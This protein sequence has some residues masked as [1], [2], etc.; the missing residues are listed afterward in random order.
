MLCPSQAK[1]FDHTFIVLLPASVKILRTLYPLPAIGK[2][3]AK[4]TRYMGQVSLGRDF[5]LGG[6]RLPPKSP[7]DLGEFPP[8]VGGKQ[9]QKKIN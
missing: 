8:H 4:Y 3:F 1:N 5:F 2:F 7:P 9:K 6:G